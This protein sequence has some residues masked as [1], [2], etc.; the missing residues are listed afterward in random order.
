MEVHIRG[1][2]EWGWEYLEGGKEDFEAEIASD[3]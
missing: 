3:I 2:Y 1:C